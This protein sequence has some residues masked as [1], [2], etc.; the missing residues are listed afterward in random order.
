M[1]IRRLLLCAMTKQTFSGGKIK[2]VAM[3]WGL[4]DVTYAQLLLSLRLRSRQIQAS[5]DIQKI[6]G[7][8]VFLD[9]QKTMQLPVSDTEPYRLL[10]VVRHAEKGL[11]W[12]AGLT[13][14][15]LRR[16]QRL[17]DILKGACIT[18]VLATDL[19]RAQ[20]TAAPTA[21][22]HDLE[23]HLYSPFPP[24]HL[25]MRMHAQLDGGA[26]LIVG[27]QNTVPALLNEAIH[28]LQYDELQPDE[29]SRFFVVICRESGAAHILEFDYQVS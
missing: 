26:S 7:T 1:R 21:A 8:Q 11:G 12:D 13:E 28:S 5:M 17:A 22:A 24:G 9:G 2:A 23:V 27:H 19:K 16:A 3:D 29:Y 18:E 4:D 20:Q 10:F 25:L 6:E 14:A 15:G